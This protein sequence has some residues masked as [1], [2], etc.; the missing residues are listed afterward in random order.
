MIDGA[1]LAE[2]AEAHLTPNIFA[3]LGLTA[4]STAGFA[5]HAHAL[6]AAIAKPLALLA[7]S[8]AKRM[9]DAHAAPPVRQGVE[10][11]LCANFGRD[12]GVKLSSPLSPLSGEVERDCLA[13]PL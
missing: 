13:E 12:S 2:E 6:V 9:D 5:R 1:G 10:E 7:R 3:K 8:T 11:R 4:A